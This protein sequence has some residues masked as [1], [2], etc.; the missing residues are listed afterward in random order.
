MNGR[1][2]QKVRVFHCETQWLRSMTHAQSRAI[3]RRAVGPVSLSVRRSLSACI[4]AYPSL[5]LFNSH[6]SLWSSVH[7]VVEIDHFFV[8]SHSSIQVNGGGT[9]QVVNYCR[10]HYSTSRQVL[11][12]HS[13]P[14]P[15]LHILYRCANK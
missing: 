5:C 15:H 6:S 4:A 2:R 1:S 11:L 14:C 12:V 10:G 9:W 3:A 7:F 13:F 8:K